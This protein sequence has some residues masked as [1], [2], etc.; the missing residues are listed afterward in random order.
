MSRV[1]RLKSADTIREE[2]GE[3]VWRLDADEPDDATREAFEG[4]L[5]EDPRHREAYDYLSR[6]WTGLDGLKVLKNDVRLRSMRRGVREEEW[7][8][9]FRIPLP[10][11]KFTAVGAAFVAAIVL[12]VVLT[13]RYAALPEA[14]LIATAVG[15]QRSSTLADGSVVDLNTNTIVEIDFH[16]TER[17]VRLQKGEAHFTVESDAERPF[18]VV[19]G[20]TTVRAVGTAFNVRRR[21]DAPVEVIVTEGKVA[22]LENAAESH[23]AGRQVVLPADDGSPR[24]VLL[25]AGQGIGTQIGTHTDKPGTAQQVTSI[26]TEAI[27]RELAW[28]QGMLVFTSERLEYVVEEL[29]RYTEV[30]FVIVDDSIRDRPVGGYFRTGDIDGL[31]SVLESGLDIEVRRQDESLVFLSDAR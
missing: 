11:V 27:D 8:R 3:W 1:H 30:R 20:D 9:R 10:A 7:R 4:W 23:V 26:D 16:D 14:Q 17:I 25:E 22:V 13:S 31:L 12:A 15:Q 24:P 18:L 29:S 2:A 19:A 6:V 5:R 21:P 28:R